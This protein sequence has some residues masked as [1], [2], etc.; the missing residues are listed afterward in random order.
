MSQRLAARAFTVTIF[1][2]ALGATAPSAAAQRATRSTRVLVIYQ[3]Q[4]ETRPMLEFAEQLR[5]TVNKELGSPVEF[6]Q[7]ALDFDRF[8][9]LEQSSPLASYLADKYHQFAIDIVVPVGGRALKFAVDQLGRGLPDVPVVFALC[10]MPQTDP[11]AQPANVTGRISPAS[12]FAPTLE[13]ARRL[14]PDAERVVVVGGA[15][16][17]DSTSVDAVVSAVSALGNAPE[18]SVLQG[19][20][21][22]ELLPKL[23]QIPTRSI[24]IFANYRLDGRGHAYEPLDI[25]GSIAH[26]AP[27]P[28]YTQLASYVGEG[29]V[30][31]SVLRFD[32]EAVRTGRLVV[33]VLRRRRG[34]PMPPV[35]LIPNTFVADSRQL[36]RWGLAEDRLPPGTELMF[37][38]PTLWERYRTVVLLTLGIIA[39]ESMLIGSLLV[40]RRRRKQAQLVAE[41][42]QRRID[43]TRRQVAHMGRVALVGELAATMSH[44]LRQPLAA[45]RMNAEAG[46]KIVARAS[47]AL[48]AED[49]AM[50]EEIFSDIVADNVLASDIITRVRALVR[51]EELRSQPVDLNEICRTSARVVQY[52]VVARHAEITFELDPGQPT[53]TGDP[54][55]LQQVVLNLLV[56]ALDASAASTTPHVTISTVV[57][58]EKVEVAVRDNGPGLSGEVQQRLF[59]SFFTT[60]PQG[61]GL[62]LPIVQSIVERHHGRVRAE[63]A[64]G[65]G[66]VFRVTLPGTRSAGE[67]ASNLRLKTLQMQ[68][69]VANGIL[70]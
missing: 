70:Q 29:V 27:A 46:A 39:A 54:V 3:Q 35:E 7:E 62:G 50:C 17:S 60:K 19:L 10:A 63:N 12:R 55:Q 49:R 42:Q 38:E 22:D 18:L 53:V 47:G 9:G 30:G 40:E 66:A 20:P 36:R 1:A 58:G 65:G 8:T 6:Y 41:E 43:E 21:L 16:P 32:D 37:R 15:G 56:N 26:A 11:T 31:G 48:D 23:R 57:Q 4:A 14:Q 2:L 33:R 52:D 45:I 25:V 44:D 51:R 67:N 28:M 13:M 34:E 24:V 61:L 5:A 68:T 64:E 69:P 59:E